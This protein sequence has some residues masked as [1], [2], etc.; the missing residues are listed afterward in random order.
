MRASE[1]PSFH[2]LASAANCRIGDV[3]GPPLLRF[4][5]PS[6]RHSFQ[7]GALLDPEADT[8][9][10]TFFNDLEREAADATSALMTSN[11]CLLEA[12][13]AAVGGKRKEASLGADDDGGDKKL[14]VAAS[15]SSSSSSSSAA[16]AAAGALAGDSE[17]DEKFPDYTRIERDLPLKK[18]AAAAALPVA[19]S[20][21]TSSSSSCSSDPSSSS[22]SASASASTDAIVSTRDASAKTEEDRGEITFKVISNADDNIDH[23]A[24]LVN[25]K[26]IFSLQLPKMPK[27]Y[28]VRLVLDRKHK[29]MCILK[30]GR[31][32][33]GISFRPFGP[34]R[35]A[36]IVFCAITSS[37]QVRVFIFEKYFFVGAATVIS[38]T[39]WVNVFL[40]TR[41]FLVHTRRVRCA[42]TAR[43]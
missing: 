7:R 37:E 20:S 38:A 34:Q 19:S 39:A 15:S 9:V 26:N 8:L 42:A 12:A 35:F 5:L 23:T 27:E 25:L 22:A 21:S 14:R 28:I 41:F 40:T 18:S 10:A 6:L 16:A 32:I 30:N 17:A 1:P 4:L 24:L 11:V 3:Y 13:N 29:A 33:G 43:D 31:V 36:E 2:V